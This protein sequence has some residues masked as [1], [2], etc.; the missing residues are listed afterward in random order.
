MS[1]VTHELHNLWL[2]REL[3]WLAKSVYFMYANNIV[4]WRGMLAMT[5]FPAISANDSIHHKDSNDTLP[6]NPW[7]LPPES[8][9][10]GRRQGPPTS[11]LCLSRTASRLPSIP[12]SPEEVCPSIM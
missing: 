10:T 8:P 5:V 11:F 2:I 3:G 12:L 1:I 4:L 6:S 9:P 7:T